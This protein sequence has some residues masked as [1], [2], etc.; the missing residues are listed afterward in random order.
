MPARVSCTFQHHE[1]A[2]WRIELGFRERQNT[3][4]HWASVICSGS[5][6]GLQQRFTW[7]TIT[8]CVP[9]YAN[10]HWSVACTFLKR[11]V[12]QSSATITGALWGCLVSLQVG[13]E[14]SSVYAMCPPKPSRSPTTMFLPS[15][16]LFEPKYHPPEVHPKKGYGEDF[17]FTVRTPETENI[18]HLP[19]A[20]C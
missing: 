4:V 14:S 7:T 3:F 13:Q 6:S 5:G 8:K 12:R 11:I 19:T 15:V 16:N 17:S 1:W 10:T 20:E 18:V 9:W 2:V